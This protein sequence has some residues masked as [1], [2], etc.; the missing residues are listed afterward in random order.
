MLIVLTD[1]QKDLLSIQPRDAAENP[2][3]VDGVPTWTVS[4]ET[5]LS[6]AVAPDGLS[7]VVTAVGPLGT[8]QVTV[9]ADADMGEGITTISGVID[10]QVVASQAVSLSVVAG[11]PEAK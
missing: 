4:D 1:M 9:S 11:V 10:I 3:P 5:I 7:A 8:A 2:A 6:L